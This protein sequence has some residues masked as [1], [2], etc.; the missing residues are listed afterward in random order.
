MKTL[1][2]LC[3]ML[4]LLLASSVMSMAQT[5]KHEVGGLIFSFQ[6][7][8]VGFGFGFGG[9]YTYNLNRHVAVDSEVNAFVEDEGPIYATQG[10][11]GPKVGVRSKYVG[12]FVKARPGFSTNF[13]R[14]APDF[15]TTFAS[16]QVTKFALDVGA[17]FEAYPSRHTAFRVDVGDVIVP[18]GNDLILGPEP[19]RLGTTH[20]FQYSLG[21]S[22]RF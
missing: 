2:M 6:G 3:G 5:P 21:F 9:R 13:S 12:V 4:L 14:A 10:F 18:L 20:N 19:R 15:A 8:H 16:E 1:V 11:V 17:V 22:L 7:K